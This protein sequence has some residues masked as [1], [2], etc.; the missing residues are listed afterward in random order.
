MILRNFCLDNGFCA[1]SVCRW[2]CAAGPAGPAG[3]PTC[4]D[5][6]ASDMF[7]HVRDKLWE[8]SVIFFHQGQ[9][10]RCIA[11][12]RLVTQIDPHDTQAYDVGEWL[13]QNQFRD[14]EAEAYLKE[15]LRNNLDVY[16]LYFSLGL[17]LL[18]A[19]ALQGSHNPIWK[20]RQLFEVPF[21]VKN[22]L[23]H[24]YEHAGLP[25]RRSMSG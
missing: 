25:G 1:S 9:Y 4:V 7:G 16:D 24:T 19:P 23:A 8:E 14:D 15:G 12:M 5:C 3:P 20:P 11:M 22:M 2:L 6:C 13:M 10:E 18:S 17:L 21:F